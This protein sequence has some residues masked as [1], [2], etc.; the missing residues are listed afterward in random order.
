MAS[1]PDVINRYYD[2]LE[3]TLIENKLFNEPHRLFL[4]VMRTGLSLNPRPL[5]VV[6]TKEGKKSILAN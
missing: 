5:K 4:I 6:D 2:I 3:R 1:D